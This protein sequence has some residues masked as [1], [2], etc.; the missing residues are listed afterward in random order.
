MQDENA[1]LQNSHPKQS[2]HERVD[3]V[4]IARDEAA[5]TDVVQHE[6]RRSAECEHRPQRGMKGRER[7][8]A[9]EHGERAAR[10]E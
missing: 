1:I 6:H 10:R 2:A 8:A 5:E 7:D 9:D 4:H 3:A